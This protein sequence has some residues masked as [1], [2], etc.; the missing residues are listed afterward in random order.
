MQLILTPPPT[1]M[2]MLKEISINY[3][4]PDCYGIWSCKCKFFFFIDQFLNQSISK[5]II[6]DNNLNLY[7]IKYL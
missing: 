7:S 6:N 3:E 4:S 5:E 2:A 1:V